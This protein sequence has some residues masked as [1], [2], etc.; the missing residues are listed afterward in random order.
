MWKELKEIIETCVMEGDGI[1]EIGYAVI[2]YVSEQNLPEDVKV[3]IE[4]NIENAAEECLTIKEFLKVAK[5]M[6]QKY[7]KL[8]KNSRL[9]LK[10][11]GEEDE[12][13][14]DNFL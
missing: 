4:E 7:I 5:P 13:E 14:I 1:E 9:Y 10:E 2:N 12:F 11:T 8:Q 3:I 6:L